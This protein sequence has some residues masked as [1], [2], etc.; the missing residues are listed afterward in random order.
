MVMPSAKGYAGALLLAAALPL[1]AQAQQPKYVPRSP[2]SISYQRSVPGLIIVRTGNGY[3]VIDQRG[4]RAQASGY[5]V[6]L[7]KRYEI[8]PRRDSATVIRQ[9]RG[10]GTSTAR[11]FNLETARKNAEYRIRSFLKSL[12]Q[13]NIP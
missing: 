4:G 1:A 5:P 3:A 12:R 10:R 9:D 11:T 7:E 6:F 8:I 2:D 13:A